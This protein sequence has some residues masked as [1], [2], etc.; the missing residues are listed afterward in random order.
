MST[1]NRTWF[2]N[3]LKKGELLVK[4]KG[5][6]TD[7]YVYDAAYNFFEDKNFKPA[8]PDLFKD[9]Y[10]DRINIYGDKNGIINVSF[11]SCEFYEFKLKQNADHKINK[12]PVKVDCQL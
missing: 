10:L 11:A 2:K 8:S 9:W 5:R 12:G 6:Y 7:D 4:C 1:I 3:R